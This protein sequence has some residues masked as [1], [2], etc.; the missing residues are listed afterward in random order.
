MS[1][2]NKVLAG[3]HFLVLCALVY[4]TSINAGRPAEASVLARHHEDGKQIV[5]S[6]CMDLLQDRAGHDTFWKGESMHGTW[7]ARWAT[8]S[9]M[10]AIVQTL[11]NGSKPPPQS[12]QS[13]VLWTEQRMMNGMLF[14]IHSF[15]HLYSVSHTG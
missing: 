15:I 9:V 11:S 13:L 5:I 14:I 7:G 8:G 10:L 4:K 6:E 12:L 2:E 1:E 3:T